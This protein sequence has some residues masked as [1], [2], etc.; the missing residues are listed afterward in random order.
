MQGT[1]LPILG[2]TRSPEPIGLRPSKLLDS[3]GSYGVCTIWNALCY[4]LHS[5]DF[6]SCFANK[7]LCCSCAQT[8]AWGPW[9]AN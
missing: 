2:N 8:R 3:A 5:H 1:K 9:T 7:A 6:F 4:M